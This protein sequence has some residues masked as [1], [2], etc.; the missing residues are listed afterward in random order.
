MSLSVRAEPQTSVG[1]QPDASRFQQYD[2]LAELSLH[3]DANFERLRQ[4]FEIGGLG[5][6]PTVLNAIRNRREVWQTA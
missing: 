6:P 5:V 1:E 3:P 2:E 4:V